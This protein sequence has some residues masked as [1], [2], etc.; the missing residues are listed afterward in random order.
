[1]QIKLKHVIQ[2]KSG[3]TVNIDED[4]KRKEKLIGVFVKSVM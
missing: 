4:V 1:M 2:S 3:T